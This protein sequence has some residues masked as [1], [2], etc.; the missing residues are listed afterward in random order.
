MYYF[1]HK[2]YIFFS[3]P[4]VVIFNAKDMSLIKSFKAEALPNNIQ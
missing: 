2:E 4:S 1:S 3:S